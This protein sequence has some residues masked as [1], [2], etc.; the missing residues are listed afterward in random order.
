MAID[1]EFNCEVNVFYSEADHK[2]FRYYLKKRFGT[3]E[4]LNEAMGTVFWNQT[5]TSW[6]EVY[7][8]RPTVSN[9]TNPICLWKKSVLYLKVLYHTVIYRLKL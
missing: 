2:A 7:L 3:L 8:T 9:S 6:D 4:A 5:Y 1:N